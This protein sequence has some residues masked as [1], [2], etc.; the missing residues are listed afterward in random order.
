MDETAQNDV[1]DNAGAAAEGGGGAVGEGVGQH[2]EKLEIETAQD[3]ERRMAAYFD[4][5]KTLQIHVNVHIIERSEI[6]FNLLHISL[7]LE[8]VINA[9]KSYVVTYSQ[10]DEYYRMDDRFTS[11]SI[12]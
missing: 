9:D 12:S 1:N 6:L 7:F 10:T 5:L 8:Y 2:S 3:A 4:F 11:M